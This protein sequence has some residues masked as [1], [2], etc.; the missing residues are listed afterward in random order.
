[1]FNR[2]IA[3]RHPALVVAILIAATVPAA[4]SF[5]CS[6]NYTFPDGNAGL[7]LQGFLPAAQNTTF[8]PGVPVG[9]NPQPDPPGTPRTL[10][11]LTG[12]T[13]RDDPD[14]Q[15]G[16][17]RRLWMRRHLAWCMRSAR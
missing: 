5:G 9:F 14:A 8:N 2:I 17:C 16:L 11:S 15:C 7:L 3:I 10:L 6:S 4:F 12:P 13:R 1:V